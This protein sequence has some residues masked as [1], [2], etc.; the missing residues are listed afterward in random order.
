M[1]VLFVNPPS[2]PYN[3]LVRALGNREIEFNQVVAMPMGILYLA[4]MLERDIP[5]I[6]V[7]V[8][9]LAK[10]S[11]DFTLSPDR[12]QT[13]IEAFAEGV[14]ADQI[15]AD[16]VPDFIGLSILFSTAHRST[17][18]IAK[19]L[20]RRWPQAPVVVGGMH[21]TND[22]DGLLAMPGI[23]YVC[24]GEAEAIIARFANTVTAGGDCEAI[25]GIYGRAKRA[26]EGGKPQEVAPAVEDLDGIPFPAWHLIPMEQYV[27]PSGRA[28][29]LDTVQLNGEATIMTTRGCPFS[30]T[31]CSSW[32]VHGRNVRFRS[33]ENVLAEIDIL[34]HRFGVRVI[35]PEDD[36]FT[37]KKARIIELCDA[38]AARFPDLGFQFPNGLSVATLDDDVIAALIRM[39][40]RVAT[41]AIES[42]SAHVQRHII[43][44][45]CN[46]ER[47]AKVVQSCRDQ[48]AIVR[49]YYVLGFPGETREMI[50]ETISFSASIAADWSVFMIAAPLVG[51]EMYQ[52]LLERG[53]ID[54]SF[55]WDE[56][57]FHER[58]FDT[59]EVT[60]AEL[61]RYST[62]A[63]IRNNFFGNYNLRIGAWD[64]AVTLFGDIIKSYP[65]HIAARYCTA[66][67][68]A[69]LGDTGGHDAALAECR[70]LLASPD[71]HPMAARIFADFPELF[72]EL[73]DCAGGP[74][75]WQRPA[76]QPRG[77]QPA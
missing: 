73:A 1:K 42:G 8:L 35:V 7:R 61:K 17:G 74:S 27:V 67:A 75:A 18:E 60:A 25:P 45:N 70:R 43:K 57:F 32:T 72:P 36:L 30:C 46:L 44:K 23:D 34:Y 19:P 13:T 4:A 62:E 65:D 76:A 50:E 59:P 58:N 15:P 55:N 5:G 68:L 47:A 21:A 38:V 51:T 71:D 64:R 16:F 3:L 20:K 9:D 12:S 53:H 10:A 56:S 28:R 6:D 77:T 66:Q 24:C 39:G 40:M 11:R 26:A 49:C 29:R 33:V 54:A 52:Q 37:V 2:M 48:G 41:I 31:F 69:Q 22:V 14:L 63:N